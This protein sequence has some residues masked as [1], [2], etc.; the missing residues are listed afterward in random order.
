L[1]ENNYKDQLDIGTLTTDLTKSCKK[2]WRQKTAERQARGKSRQSINSFSIDDSGKKTDSHK[3]P[4]QRLLERNAV[5]TEQ[6]SNC[7][8]D[9]E[10]MCLQW[11]TVCLHCTKTFPT[12]FK[13]KSICFV[14]NSET[15][16]EKGLF[17]KRD[18]KKDEYIC[19]YVGKKVANGTIGE[20]VVIVNSLLTIDAL[21]HTQISVYLASMLEK[22]QTLCC[23]HLS[24]LQETKI[25]V[26][27]SNQKLCQMKGIQET[28][29][30]FFSLRHGTKPLILK[31]LHCRPF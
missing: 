23:N 10:Q 19:R 6:S 30:L 4:I 25:F 28:F 16:G 17:A 12:E 13:S 21:Q 31:S 14:D 26:I 1:S 24:Q 11:D 15:I 7:I 3:Y 27:Y 9:S 18:I 20:Y 8:G 22:Q 29:P 5:I 2:H